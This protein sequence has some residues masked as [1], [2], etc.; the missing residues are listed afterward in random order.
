MKRSR[1]RSRAGVGAEAERDRRQRR[2]AGGSETQKK[3]WGSLA[4]QE[5]TACLLGVISVFGVQPID[6]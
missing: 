5:A 1:E 3:K 6:A 4:C 2:G